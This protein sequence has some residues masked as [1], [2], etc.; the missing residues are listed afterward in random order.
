VLRVSAIARWRVSP[1]RGA[2]P[3][4]LPYAVRVGGHLVRAD[5]SEELRSR[6]VALGESIGFT[7]A[8]P[9]DKFTLTFASNEP[10]AVE[11]IYG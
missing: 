3:R 2:M 9:A 8:G 4:P 11:V 10:V 1:Y 6:L 5:D 7:V